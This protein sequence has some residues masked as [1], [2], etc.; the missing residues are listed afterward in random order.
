MGTIVTCNDVAPPR[1]QLEGAWYCMHDGTLRECHAPRIFPLDDLKILDYAE[2]GLGRSIYTEQQLQQFY[3]FQQ[4]AGTRTAFLADQAERA[5]V[6]RSANG[7][8]G[9]ALGINARDMMLDVVGLSFIPL[10]RFFGP[11]SMMLILVFFIIGGLRI[12]VTLIVRAIII[13]RT[14][15]CGIW[16]LAAVYGT[17][18]QIVITPMRWADEVAQKIA[19]EVEDR[20]ID[21]SERPP[22]EEM[23]PMKRLREA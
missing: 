9:L 19:H 20:M 7:D 17:I 13:A 10:Y 6:M 22:E 2:L 4:A 11:V 21:E 12:C 16:I 15:G 5:Y 8:W 18:Y 23:Y 14:K 3:L 1:F